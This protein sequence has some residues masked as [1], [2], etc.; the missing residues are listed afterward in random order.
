MTSVFSR[1]GLLAGVMTLT[2]AVAASAQT[3]PAAPDGPPKIERRVVIMGGP[4]GPGMHGP[5]GPGMHGP[6]MGMH[7]P[8]DPAKHAD[9]LR[10]MLQLRPDQEGALQA[11]IGASKPMEHTG[12]HP[13]AADAP[14]PK[15]LTTLER[16]DKHARMMAEHQAAFQKH[17]AAVRAFY[18]QLSPSQQKAFDAMSAMMH[19]GRGGHGGPGER[20]MRVIRH[21][22]PGAPGG[23]AA[24]G[25]HGGGMFIIDGDDD[26]EAFEIELDAPDAPGR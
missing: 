8:M 3:P 22:G 19:G 14:P 5:G 15:P 25:G 21:G 23:P 7:A 20:H 1:A 12:G 10:V 11:F 6:G 26:E 16:L 24:E 2:F 17:A 18:N 13:A 4:G 9:H